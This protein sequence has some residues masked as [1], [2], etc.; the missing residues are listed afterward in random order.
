[1]RVASLARCPSAGPRLLGVLTASHL[2]SQPL[3]SKSQLLPQAARR[4]RPAPSF[5]FSLRAAVCDIYKPPSCSGRLAK[6]SLLLLPLIEETKG[7]EKSDGTWLVSSLLTCFE[8]HGRICSLSVDSYT[9]YN[10][11]S[12]HLLSTYYALPCKADVTIIP[13]LQMKKKA[14][15]C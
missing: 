8:G 2:C 13:I 15:S 9:Q 1:M 6:C 11:T 12:R 10:A 14:C 5:G 4:E 3:S 7:S